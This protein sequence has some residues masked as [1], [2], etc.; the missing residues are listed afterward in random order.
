MGILFGLVRANFTAAAELCGIVKFLSEVDLCV[1][2]IK[3]FVEKASSSG[4]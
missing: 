3:L 2:L 4:Y 1:H